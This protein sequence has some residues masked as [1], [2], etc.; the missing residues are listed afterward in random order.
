MAVS[1]V[2]TG[3][4]RPCAPAR[5]HHDMT[6]LPGGG[7]DRDRRARHQPQRRTETAR[8]SGARPLRRQVSQG[9]QTGQQGGGAVSGHTARPLPRQTGQ[10]GGGRSVVTPR[11]LYADRSVRADRRVSR[12]GGQRSHRAPS[13]PTGQSGPTD[14]SAGGGGQGVGAASGHSPSGLSVTSICNLASIALFFS[15]LLMV[16]ALFLWSS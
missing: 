13:T 2:S 9:R 7:R 11:A 10:Q 15:G 14:G 3:T 1:P 4:S 6:T 12:G 8:G 16:F 5:S